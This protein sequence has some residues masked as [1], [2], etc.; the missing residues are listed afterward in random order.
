MNTI[1]DKLVK[2]FH[3][4][5]KNFLHKTL[6]GWLGLEESSSD[7]DRTITIYH[8][9]S[10]RIGKYEYA[11]DTPLSNFLHDMNTKYHTLYDKEIKDI[12]SE[13]HSLHERLEKAAKRVDGNGW[14][15]HQPELI[16]NIFQGSSKQLQGI[17]QQLNS[18]A[19][20]Y[21]SYG[22]GIED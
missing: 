19:N 6:C 13:L 1:Q 9:G 3:L 7:R 15:K 20:A 21:S 8:N 18:V 5:H 11:E 22:P 12:V 14:A 2:H 10:I 16:K 4:P 17:Y